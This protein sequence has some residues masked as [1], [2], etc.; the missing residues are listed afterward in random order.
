[1]IGI[2]NQITWPEM[3]GNNTHLWEV[4]NV[5]SETSYQCKKCGTYG[6]ASK[7]DP[8]KKIKSFTIN[9]DEYICDTI[10]GY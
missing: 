1:M 4:T 6:Y 8:D 2:S 3:H 10:H 5:G 7:D 9:C